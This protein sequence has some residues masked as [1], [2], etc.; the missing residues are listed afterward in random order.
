[1][2][3]GVEDLAKPYDRIER[4]LPSLALIMAT[5][6]PELGTVKASE[7]LLYDLYIDLRKKIRQ[8]AAITKQTAQARMGYIGQ[9]LVSVVTGH[10][11][12]RSGARGKD[13][14]LSPTEYAEIKT[15]YRVDQL[16]KCNNC[17]AA[18]ASIEEL[19]PKCGSDDIARGDDSK[20]LIGIR[21]EDEF[22]TLLEPKWYFLALFEFADPPKVDTILASIW[23][24][25]PRC[26]GFALCLVDY[27]FNIQAN[28]KSGAP[29][30][31]WPYMLK[32]DLMRPLLIYRARINSDD[33]IETLIFPGRDTPLPNP[34]KPLDDYASSQNLSKD[35]VASLADDLGIV[36]PSG[37]TAKKAM[38]QAIEAESKKRKISYNELTDAIARAIYSERIRPFVSKLPK[39]LRTEIESKLVS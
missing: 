36:L 18:V 30:N 35:R 6:S 9:H 5:K 19:C 23:R 17:E 8:W 28:S 3:L 25:D 31:L 38:L 4:V 14:I 16:G 12:G 26:P 37:T 22:R 20:W 21:N 11:G 32:F 2:I 7:Q 34:L 10:E 27:Y 15:C 29:F 24:V 13:L 33:S 39:E 1:M